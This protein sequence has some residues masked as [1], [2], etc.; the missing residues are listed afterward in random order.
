[1]AYVRPT[2][3]KLISQLFSG[4]FA[5]EYSEKIS[6]ANNG[7]WILFPAGARLGAV[8][9]ENIAAGTA[10]LQL[11]TYKVRD[12]KSNDAVGVDWEEG[13]VT[14]TIQKRVEPV[15]A[16]RVVSASGTWKISVTFR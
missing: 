14:A 1:M 4:A 6:G 10:K 16:I 9:L 11:T 12:V 7:S 3:P 8:T 13:D 15:T 2:R 5:A